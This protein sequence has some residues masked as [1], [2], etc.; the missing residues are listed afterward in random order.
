[1]MRWGLDTCVT[2]FFQHYR[3]LDDYIDDFMPT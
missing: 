3:H 2:I 1:M